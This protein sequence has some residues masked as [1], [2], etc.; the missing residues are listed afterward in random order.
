MIE[1]WS[2]RT[3]NGLRAS[4]MLEELGLPYTAHRV[5]FDEKAALPPAMLA[6]N[7]AGAIPVM[8]DHETG[9]GLSQ[10][11]AIMLYLCEKAGY[12]L[13]TAA[14]AR[15]ATLQWMSFVMTDVISAT[16]PIFVLGSEL[17]DTPPHI[18]AHYEAR[19][20]RFFGVADA[21]LESSPYLAGN[22]VTVADFAL[23]PTAAFRTKLLDRMGGVPHL[24]DWMARMAARPG[25]A[26][27]MLVPG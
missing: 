8:R 3:T 24:R 18:I 16:H 21:R 26:R 2:A 20:M 22:D 23:Y 9:I 10:S 6:I 12:F 27:G 19:L 11:F 4:I 1:L 15:A 5:D 25:V 14:G 7:P 17:Q 13:S